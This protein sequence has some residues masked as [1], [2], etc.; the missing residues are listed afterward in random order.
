M[1]EYPSIIDVYGKPSIKRKEKK[2]KF[3]EHVFERATIRGVAN[4]LLYG[5]SPEKEVRDYETRLDDAY[6]EYEKAVQQCEKPE[7][8]ALMEVTDALTSETANVYTEIGL[9]AGLLLI[10]DMVQNLGM[11]KKCE[12]DENANYRFMYDLLF[13]EV[14]CALKV[15]QEEENIRKAIN[16]LK[17]GQCRAEEVY[18]KSE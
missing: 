17:E 9:Q 11:H 7:K 5:Q 14:T 15:L 18:L 12:T 4:Y 10:Q 13:R 2:M 6:L 1:Y 16:I 8:S 3:T